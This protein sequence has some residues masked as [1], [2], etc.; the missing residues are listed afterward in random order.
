MPTV[1]S[2]WKRC[3]QKCVQIYRIS[4]AGYAFS[5]L[6]GTMSNKRVNKITT[7][8]MLTAIT[9]VVMLVGRVPI[10]PGFD[11]LK[12]DPSDVIVTLGGFIW[13]PLVSFIVSPVVA[14]I[15]MIT[16][17]GT[18]PIGFLMNVI[19]TLSFAGTATL[20]YKKKRTL[21]GAV[22]GL[23]IATAFTTVVMLL[24]NYLITPIYQNVPR[25]VV[26][27]ML[28]PI[29]LPFNLLKS[30][31]NA[32]FTFLLYKP[33]VSALSKSKKIML[34]ENKKKGKFGFFTAVF[35]AILLASVIAVLLWNNII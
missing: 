23:L 17:S 13:G 14:F 22:C 20:I 28:V 21:A 33:V 4:R 27:E 10:V 31:I 7:I 29:F 11:F 16:A 34:V 26:K 19:Q 2:G 15:E 24:W 18:G 30:A 1:K 8:A 9:Y 6:G 3:T 35:V 12:Y 25:D 32:S 5:F